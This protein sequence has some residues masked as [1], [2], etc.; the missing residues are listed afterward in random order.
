MNRDVVA[1]GGERES[2]P[3]RRQDSTQTIPGPYVL[4]SEPQEFHVRRTTSTSSHLAGDTAPG[5]KSESPTPTSTPRTRTRNPTAATDDTH[6]GYGLGANL[7]RAATM[8][9][10]ENHRNTIAATSETLNHS[11]S[12]NNPL[13]PLP[14]AQS[15]LSHPV[16]D[17]NL[18]V[19]G[20]DPRPG[21]GIDWI[22][23]V[24]DQVCSCTI[25]HP[26]FDPGQTYRE[27]TF[28]ERLQP[29]LDTAQKERAKYARKAKMTGYALNIAI[30]SFNLH[31]PPH[32]LNYI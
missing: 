32:S 7:R 13:P 26:H 15:T 14:P 30:G 18:I 16:G 8:P 20:S 10:N 2:P 25:I 3:D 6:S 5:E 23:P 12:N 28:A 27:R 4:F 21:P 9:Q 29:T 11:N 22:V 1:P 19:N 24:R 31:T 17:L